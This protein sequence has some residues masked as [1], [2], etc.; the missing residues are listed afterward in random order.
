MRAA[1][2]RPVTRARGSRPSTATPPTAPASSSSGWTTPAMHNGIKCQPPAA[3]K[4]CFPK[5]RFAIDLDAGTVTCPAGVTAPIRASGSE[6]HAGGG[7]VRRGVPGLPAGRPVHEGHRRPHDHH[8][9][10]RGPPGRRPDPPARPG[11]EGGLPGHPAEGRAEDRPPDAPPPR[12]PPRPRPRPGQGRRRLRAPGRRGQPRPA[13]RTRARPPR[14]NLGRARE[15]SP[16]GHCPLWPVHP[17]ARLQALTARALLL[18]QSPAARRRAPNGRL[19]RPPD[20]T[21]SQPPPGSGPGEGRSTP[22]T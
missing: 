20:A 3:V 12:R 11:L 17:P 16:G 1:P 10:A 19:A 22:A 14:R 8:R 5:D 4:G 2:A 13:R 9:P 15:L 21:R 7:P 18:S 6:R